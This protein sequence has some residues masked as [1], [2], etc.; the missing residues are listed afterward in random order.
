MFRKLWQLFSAVY[1]KFKKDDSAY[2]IPNTEFT[3]RSKVLTGAYTGRNYSWRS[4]TICWNKII[5]TSATLSEKIECNGISE[6]SSNICHTV[7]KNRMQRYIKSN[8]QHLSHC[9]KQGNATVYQK[10]VPTSVILSETREC[11]GISEV[12]SNICHT[13]RNKGMK[14]HIRSKL[15]HL[16]HCQKQGNERA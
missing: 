15:R 9:K 7:R 11:N 13:V 5:S 8:F 16:L 14:R 3:L 4:C 2:G 10:Y 12:S 6:V 1:R